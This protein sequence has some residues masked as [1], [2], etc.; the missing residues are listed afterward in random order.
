M[1]KLMFLIILWS[2]VRLSATNVNSC[3]K[4]IRCT[5]KKCFS[6]AKTTEAIHSLNASGMF[7][8]I[9]DQFSFVCIA[10]KCRDPCIT[11]ERCNY[12]LNQIS[13]IVGGLKTEMVCPKM[14]TCLKKCFQEDAFRIGPCIRKQCNT[15]C[16]DDE[17]SHCTYIAKREKKQ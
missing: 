10:T 14:E 3:G 8:A 2:V 12:A 7:S 6:T 16:F 9:I 13:R 4:L 1:I 5:I 15:H 17:C 11:C